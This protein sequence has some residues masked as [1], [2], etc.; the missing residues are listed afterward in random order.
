VSTVVAD[1]PGVTIITPVK[2]RFGLSGEKYT[3]KMKG[4]S[5]M[6][7]KKEL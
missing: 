3:K 1:I 4:V 6:K 2:I 5:S 7:L